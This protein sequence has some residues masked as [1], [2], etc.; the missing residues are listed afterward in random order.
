[1]TVGLLSRLFGRKHQTISAA[2]A[3]QALQEGAVL[4]D[5]RS[6]SE[7]NAGHAPAARHIPVENIVRQAGR[8]SKGEP[9]VTICRSGVRSGRAA[10]ALADLGY[11]ASSVRG[12][13]HAWQRA[14]GTIVG[15]NG[16]AGTVA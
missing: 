16:R 11:R 9:I 15:R 12:G 13:M 8:L 4:V 6:D 1:M 3:M 10:A 5:V 2:A 7:W 14:G